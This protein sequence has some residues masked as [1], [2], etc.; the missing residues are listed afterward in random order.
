MGGRAR[1]EQPTPT[2][3]QRTRWLLCTLALSSTAAW[4]TWEVFSGAQHCECVFALKFLVDVYIFLMSS[5]PLD[6][7]KS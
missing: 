2:Q 5:L 6:N 1:A 4:L 7:V 3:G